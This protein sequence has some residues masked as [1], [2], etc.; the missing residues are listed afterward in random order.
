[1]HILFIGRIDSKLVISASCSCD[2]LA[3]GDIE[4]YGGDH[5]TIQRPDYLFF[6]PS[7]YI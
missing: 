1:M 2:I 4:L 7:I 5:V 3:P 6:P